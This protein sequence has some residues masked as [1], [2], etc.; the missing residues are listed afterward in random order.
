MRN[1]DTLARMGYAAIAGRLAAGECATLD[2]AVS[3]ELH[4][5]GASLDA[6]AALATVERPDL[7]ES[8]HA[9]YLAAGADVISAN[10]F[11]CSEPRLDAFGL[12]GRMEELNRS[13]VALARAA[14]ERSGGS[15][16]VAGCV[17]TVGHRGPDGTLQATPDEEWA[18]ARQAEILADAGAEL[19]IVEMLS[20]VAHANVQL[21]AAAR[22]GLPVWAG[23]SCAPLGGGD[24]GAVRLL[25]ETDEPFE[26]SLRRIDLSGAGAALVMHTTPDIAAPALAALRRV[27]SGLVGAYPHGGR[28]Q[29]P[30][31]DFD[32][33][34][35]P[36]ALAARAGEW[37]AAESEVG[38]QLVGGCCGTTPEHIR[39]LRR[40]V[41]A[42]NAAATMQGA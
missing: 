40:V 13:A 5:R 11:G 9:D 8:V 26:E 12:A 6:W 18:L 38:C 7:L 3:T 37:L 32:P 41:D 17:T 21:A 19:I 10:T 14:R 4:R 35:T 36:E 25:G 31:W 2:G 34:F 24:S 29:G 15:A 22:A 30:T 39:A 27:W 33:G 42:A 28:W 1:G 16:V 20:S 23:F